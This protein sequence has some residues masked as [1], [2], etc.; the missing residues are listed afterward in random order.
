MS[1]IVI[2]VSAGDPQGIGPEVA[3]AAIARQAAA[4]PEVRYRIHGDAAQLVAL[5]A[6]ED[7][8]VTL[9]DRPFDRAA[10]TPPP[11]P[12]GG[13]A[14]LA[15]LESAFD[16]VV[17]GRADALCTAPLSKEAVA[18]VAPGFTGHTGWLSKRCGVRAQ[19]CLASEALRVFLLTEHL[20][21]AA[22]PA[23]LERGVVA[24]FLRATRRALR[25]DLGL[26][27]P[28]VA[29]L[30]LNPHAGE[31]GHLGREEIDVL[32]PALADA[33]GAEAGFSG[34]HSAD[35]FFRAERLE[36]CDAVVACYHD[37]GLIPLKLLSFGRAA[38]L[39][40]GLPVVRTS[41]DHGTAYDLAGRGLA[42]AGSMGEALEWAV[43]IV[44]RRRGR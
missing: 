7:E 8:R 37:Q 39:S 21:L 14:A 13:R 26:E 43:R 30:A 16:D 17:S 11:G 23:A 1:G 28:R 5:G 10:L 19:M 41:P 38:N 42:D 25:E 15:A 29:L 12:E 40:F 6:R 35:T 2:A 4:R 9:V 34:P 24:D 33:G 20:P 27:A 44:E 32:V 18:A 31:G 3:V 36:A 22:V